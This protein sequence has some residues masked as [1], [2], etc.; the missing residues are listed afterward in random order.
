M[1]AFLRHPFVRRHLSQSLR[2]AVCG[3]IG[4]LIDLTTLHGLLTYGV[5]ARIAVIPSTLL[6]VIFVFLSNKFFTF[7]NRDSH[8][9]HQM[10]K[11]ALVY[12]VAVLSNILISIA[13]ITIGLNPFLAKIIA[14]AIGAIWN[15]SLSHG[16]VFR[17]K[18]EVDAVVV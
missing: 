13:L 18:E 5:S 12:G 15:Y 17:K 4:S 3:G 6:A 8:V 1:R 11:F 2:F 9:G 14:I 10:L 7:R 16:F